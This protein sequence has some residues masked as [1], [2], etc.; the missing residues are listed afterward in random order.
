[1]FS[2]MPVNCKVLHCLFFPL[3]RPC[4]VP[5]RAIFTSKDFAG[6]AARAAA[7]QQQRTRKLSSATKKE[8]PK[9]DRFRMKKFHHVEFYCG[10]A[11]AAA[12]RFIWGLGMSLVAKSDQSTGNTQHA[13]YVVQSNDLRFVCTAPY[14]L[15]SAAP[16]PPSSAEAAVGAVNTASS[17]SPL[18][19][20]DPKAAHEFFRRHGMAGRAIGIE[21]D[22]AALAYEQCLSHSGRG[23]GGSGGVSVSVQPPARVTDRDGRGSAT[24][25]E[26][27]AY[28]DVVLRFIS[29]DGHRAGG[30]GNT[31]AGGETAAAAKLKSETE[32]GT[33]TNTASNTEFG[34]TEPGTDSEMEADTD[35]A[36][37]GAFLPNF[38]DVGGGEPG[39][40]PPQGYGLE[41]AD[42]I[43]GNVWD[44]LEHGDYITGMT[45]M[46]EFA[47]F[48]A[49]DVG[50]IDSG[51]NSIVLASNNQM[52][53]LPLNE[54]TFGT[55]K[56][57]QIQTFLEQNEGP[58]LQHIAL[59]TNDIFRT[60]RL[61]RANS[62]FGGFEFMDAPGEGY[63]RDVP[64]RIPS[65][66][67]N[68][69]K[70][71][72]EL[73]LLADKDDDGVLLQVFTKPV[74][75]R[76]TLFFEIIQRIGCPFEATEGDNEGDRGVT[77]PIPDGGGGVVGVV[78][79]GGRPGEVLQRGG[80]GG[81][82]LGNFK[83]LF[84][85]IE[86][87]ESTLSVGTGDE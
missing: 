21:V 11:T 37:S 35:G 1:M 17:C 2:Q 59:K 54:P 81:F 31:G 41:R 47:E 20:Y 24:I 34:N 28:G 18:P 8:N 10:D 27:K 58:G 65:L 36:F 49:A 23:G 75:D 72:E 13:S 6:L 15:L 80:C 50:T 84:E 52:V 73:G 45:G 44:M 48:S 87:Y 3:A 40:G 67:E 12:S 5:H 77:S 86:K 61:M 62:G 70:Q 79:T 64:G 78:G 68:Q 25:A 42:H 16:S 82:G 66:T 51:L 63:Y 76:P 60:M 7:T 46:H 85:S 55:A 83:A 39:A 56:K 38:V 30:R 22:D 14:S 33:E 32:A 19:G 69:L 74:G 71:L 26:V 9:T 29:F 53:L 57:S 4:T 43:V